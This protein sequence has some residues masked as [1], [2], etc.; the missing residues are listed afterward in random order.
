MDVLVFV[1]GTLKHGFPN[2]SV[3]AG[4]RL[5]GPAV[6]LALY[7][8]R[9]FGPYPGLVAEGA[10]AVHGEVWAVS[11]RGLARLD[12]FEG[13]DAQVFYRAEIQLQPPFATAQAY[14]IKHGAGATAGTAIPSGMYTAHSRL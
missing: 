11:P 1:Y 9:D 3:L 6:T 8:F 10:T 7:T 4:A 14:F 12:Q 2:N 5:L 13:V